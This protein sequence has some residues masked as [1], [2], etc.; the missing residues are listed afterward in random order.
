MAQETVAHSRAEQASTGMPQL[1]FASF[2]NQIFWLLVTLVLIYIV[3]SRIAIPRIADILDR[4]RTSIE[5]NIV[6]ADELHQM[7][8][9]AEKNYEKALDEAHR[10]ASGIIA[11]AKENIQK[12]LNAAIE[13]ANA[14]IAEKSAQSE[15]HIATIRANALENVQKVAQETANAIVKSLSP[16]KIDANVIKKIVASHIKE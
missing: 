14:Q 8:Q 3:M 13:E 7:A 6:R 16:T 2:P 5:G 10:E 11:E 9:D 1:D 15:E 12:E 4:R